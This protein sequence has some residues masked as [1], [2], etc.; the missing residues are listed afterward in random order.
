M[1][2]GFIE[3][4]N[5]PGFYQQS[6]ERESRDFQYQWKKDMRNRSLWYS[7]KKKIKLAFEIGLQV[8]ETRFLKTTVT[9]N[10][11]FF[12]YVNVYTSQY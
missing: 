10:D 6:Y 7:K 2:N 1:W 12:T 3:K 8:N 5:N 9:K 4:K 11:S